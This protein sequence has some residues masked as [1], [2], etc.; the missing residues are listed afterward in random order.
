MGKA[1]RNFKTSKRLDLALQIE[2]A[3][4]ALI[5]TEIKTRQEILETQN[6]KLKNQIDEQN[7]SI[8]RQGDLYSILTKALEQ[9]NKLQEIARDLD[10]AGTDFIIGQLEVLS[11]IE[12]S[13]YRRKQIA[14]FTESIKLQSLRKQQEFEKQSLLNQIE[15]NRLALEREVIQN[16]ISQGEKVAAIA[17]AKADIAIAEA[18]PRN[19]SEAGRAKIAAMRLKLQSELDGLGLLQ[20]EGG[21]IFQQ[22][23]NQK[24]AAEAQLKQLNLKQQLDELKQQAAFANSLPPGKRQQA[25][26][27]I[28][29][30]IFRALGQDGSSNFFNAAIAQSRGVAKE[31]FGTSTNPDVLG[32]INPEL[33]GILDVV[34]GKAAAAAIADTVQSFNQQFGNT[35]NITGALTTGVARTPLQL[36]S[37]VQQVQA[38][39]DQ[40]L[41]TANQPLSV[42]GGASLKLPAPTERGVFLSLENSGQLFKEGVNK[43]ID[44]L[45][46][47][48]ITTKKGSTYNIKVDA[49]QKT[50]AT[51]GNGNETSL[52]NVLNYAKQM[53]GAY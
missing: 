45:K 44:Y 51:S 6:Q 21:L 20:A 35:A 43:L 22:F 31:K 37:D 8:K 9:R 24:V 26:R 29:D 27:V 53:A 15:Q 14:E 28:Q 23:N 50:T 18:D 16:R 13:E 30:N 36:P 47:Q 10:K 52:E 39:S 4:T 48:S 19:N 42:L 12:R 41:K 38:L 7:Q 32:A 46:D 40:I 1:N 49:P 34:G 3:K 33:G 17:S 11:S 25:Q 2:K 5:N